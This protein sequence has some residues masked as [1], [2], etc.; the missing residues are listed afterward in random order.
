M[1]IFPL[2]GTAALCLGLGMVIGRMSSSSENSQDTEAGEDNR[3]G[4]DY[5][6]ARR[7]GAGVDDARR[8]GKIG[9]TPPASYENRVAH[10]KALAKKVGGGQGVPDFDALFGI[11]ETAREMNAAEIRQAMD[12]LVRDS[13]GRQEGMFVKM[14]LVMQLAKKDGPEAMSYAMNEKKGGMMMPMEGM[15]L[16]AWSGSDPEGAYAWYLSNKDV[17]KPR[18]SR[19]FLAGAIAG[20]AEKDFSAA[21]E[22]AKNVDSLS[23]KDVLQSMGTVAADN[24]EHRKEFTDY[25]RTLEDAS[26][27]EQAAATLVGQLVLTDVQEAIQYVE[28]WEG[29]GQED[30]TDRLASQWAQIEPEKALNWQLSQGQKNSVHNSFGN[31]AREDT[32]TARKWL[33]AQ[34]GDLNKDKL[35]GSAAQ[36]T[37]WDEDYSGAAQWASSI[38]DEEQQQESYSSIYRQWSNRD[39]EGANQWLETLDEATREAIV[40][41][42]KPL[43]AAP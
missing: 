9:G 16:Q 14:M 33:S 7:S 27:R 11:W 30:L 22:K 23:R 20:L 32:E 24:P 3:A 17:L 37:M 8:V 19:Q 13:M 42:V 34:E 6:S 10:M 39:K 35:R 36:R 38:Q 12:D 21:L 25:L 5:R 31:W 40:P 41:E 1:K 2:L 43:R 18:E 15:A 29:D 26:V 4:S 28:E